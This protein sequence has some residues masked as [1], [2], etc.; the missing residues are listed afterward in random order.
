MEWIAFTL[1]GKPVDVTDRDPHTTLLQYVRS[2]GFVGTKEGCAEGEC[3]ARAVVLLGTGPDGRPRYEAVNSCLLLLPM[4]AGRAVWTVE[5]VGTPEALH[6]VQ[7]AVVRL[8]G[9]QCGYCTP[10]FVMSLFAEYYRPDRDGFDEEAISG[11]LCRC[12]GYRPIREAARSLGRPPQD[13]P[14]LAHLVPPPPLGPL[15]YAAQG[16]RFDRSTSLQELLG[17]LREAPEAKLVAGG[18]DVVVESTLLGRRWPHLV[19]VEG[20]PELR[21]LHRTEDAFVIGAALSLREI[22]QLF[23]LFASRLIRT[24]ATLGGN[25][26]TASPIG[27]ASCVL[28]AL[29]AEVCVAGPE[30]DRRIPLD[31]F[32]TGYRRTALQP[33][34]VIVSVRIP[35]PLLRLGRFYKV[36][37]RGQDDISTVAAA[38]AVDLDQDGT[39][40]RA[41]LAYGGVAPTPARARRA[42]QALVGRPWARATVREVWEVLREEFRPITDHRGSAA[43][44]RA[45]VVNLFDRRWRYE[46]GR[47]PDPSRERSGARDGS[48]ALHRRPRGTLPRAAARV[49][50]PRPSRPRPGPGDPPGGGA[51]DARGRGRAHGG[52]R[53]R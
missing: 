7:E 23:P 22:E 36:A 34:E 16:R 45:M 24:R 37:K 4:V 29:D 41:R 46:D 52:R 5:A 2:L 10:G 27:D 35:R 12:T 21:A 49:A 25:L 42:E 32:F 14:F 3:G 48:G 9:S 31:A 51:P 40:R 44:R 13:D 43:Y 50:G 33:G 30:G 19:S 26:A 17:L 11:N 20:V 47:P 6:P 38:F 1:N 8:G 15:R 28:L 18:T 39:V 53:A